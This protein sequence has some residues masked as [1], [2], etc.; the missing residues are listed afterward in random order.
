MHLVSILDTIEHRHRLLLAWLFGESYL[1]FSEPPWGPGNM[2][3]ER[4]SNCFSILNVLPVSTGVHFDPE[5]EGT[6][7]SQNMDSEKQGQRSDPCG[8]RLTDRESCTRV[9]GTDGTHRLYHKIVLGIK[10]NEYWWPGPFGPQSLPQLGRAHR[11]I[12]LSKGISPELI[13]TLPISL[14]FL[15][16]LKRI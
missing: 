14:S 6:L 5:W 11:S 4:F 9:M 8:R 1:L 10:Q 13:W 15:L 16:P 12:H 7:L 2:N 3:M